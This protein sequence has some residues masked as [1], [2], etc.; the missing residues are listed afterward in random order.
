MERCSEW[1]PVCMPIAAALQS[2]GAAHQAGHEACHGS[3]F[4]DRLGAETVLEI[5]S[6][7][8]L[9]SA[10]V[11]AQEVHIMKT[12]L[13]FSL[14]LAIAALWFAAAH[15]DILILN[16]GHA[17]VGKVSTTPSGRYKVTIQEGELFFPKNQVAN[18]WVTTEGMEAESYYQAGVLL[19]NK[20]HRETARKLFERC[21]THDA[22]YR[23]K[24]NAALRGGASPLAPTRPTAAGTPGT[25]TPIISPPRPQGQLLRIQC[26]ECSG[27]GSVMGGSSLG[28]DSGTER[29]RPCPICGARGFK[30]LRLRAGFELCSDCG[31]FGASM[32]QSGGG[33]KEGGF[34]LKKDMCPRCA[35]R[36]FVKA[37]WKPPEATPGTDNTGSG[38]PGFSPSPGTAPPRGVPNIIRDRARN[39]AS[40]RPPTRPIGPSGVRPVSPTILED[41]SSGGFD[42]GG[43]AS[44]SAEVEEEIIEEESGSSSDTGTGGGSEESESGEDNVSSDYEQPGFMGKV[45]KY[46]WYIV[47]GGCVLLV[48]A[49]AY[50]KMS[51]K[52]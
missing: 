46:K 24:C 5:F 3:G 27:T 21:V 12:I 36:G 41:P 35:G 43:G 44:P 51:A 23:D 8:H 40:G 42:S 17:Y 32:G 4:S 48:F 45:N 19:L 14:V 33:G 1:M 49:V 25:A 22:S 52:R 39:V 13:R 26:P 10:K 15:A 47:L 16:N 9:N 28:Q 7:S 18:F 30:D 38:T 34:T 2:L 50:S 29:R 11:Q 6:F 20:G 37:P 31:G